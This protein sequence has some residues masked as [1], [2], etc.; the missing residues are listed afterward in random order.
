MGGDG[1]DAAVLAF[2]GLPPDGPL[3]SGQQPPPDAAE[4][5]ALDEHRRT[6]LRAVRERLGRRDD[7]DEQL[8]HLVCARRGA[9][10]ADP[11]WIELHL[12]AD[13]IS[14]DVRRCGLD[15]DPGWLPWLGAVVRFRYV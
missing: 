5:A 7:S 12:P 3:P 15:R 8:A 11:G 1:S 13:S 4:L 6:L 14:I 10:V 9:I 2:A